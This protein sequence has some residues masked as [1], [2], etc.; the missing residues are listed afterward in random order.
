MY[1][2]LERGF[3]KVDEVSQ[4]NIH[5]PH[6]SE[7]LFVMDRFDL[8]HR[9]DFDNHLTVYHHVEPHLVVKFQ[10]FINYLDR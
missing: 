10:S 8:L 7:Q 2:I 5:Q 3:L 1:A 4:F 9:L 6:V